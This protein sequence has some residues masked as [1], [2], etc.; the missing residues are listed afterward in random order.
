MTRNDDKEC[1]GVVVIAGAVVR[2]VLPFLVGRTAGEEEEKGLLV[3]LFFLM[4]GVLGG[5]TSDG[6]VNGSVPWGLGTV[7]STVG[8]RQVAVVVEFV[9]KV[10]AVSI[11]ARRRRLLLLLVVVVGDWRGTGLSL[12]LLPSL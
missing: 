6:L 2:E 5:V 4:R 1:F 12:V 8:I 10:R 11:E 3:L 9:V 7:I